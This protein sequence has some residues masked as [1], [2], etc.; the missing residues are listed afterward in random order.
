MSFSQFIKLLLFKKLLI[1][2]DFV[3][4]H[5]DLGAL[6]EIGAATAGRFNKTEPF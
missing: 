3:L 1:Q 4:D 5:H 2:K 6:K